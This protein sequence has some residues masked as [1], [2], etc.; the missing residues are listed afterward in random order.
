MSRKGTVTVLDM[1][2]GRRLKTTRRLR[3]ISQKAVGNKIGVS[4]QQI[5]KYESGANRLPTTSFYYM[6]KLYQVSFCRILGDLEHPGWF[7]HS[8]KNNQHDED[9]KRSMNAPGQEHT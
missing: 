2:L 1:E 5:Q 8:N 6:C 9:P 7:D 3:G 4:Y